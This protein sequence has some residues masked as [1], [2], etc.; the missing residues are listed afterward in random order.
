[1]LSRTQIVFLSALAVVASST[2]ASGESAPCLP[3]EN[4][5]FIF[6]VNFDEAPGITG[7]FQVEGCEGTSPVLQI[8]R[9]VEYE[10]VQNAMTNWNHPI[11]LAYYPD[12]ALGFGNFS[13]VPELENPTPEDCESEDFQCN[14]GAD[15]EQAPLYCSNG[16]CETL[17]DWN[18]GETGLDFY[19]PYFQRPID[20]WIENTWSVRITIPLSSL[21]SQFFYF[22]HIHS[23]MSGLINVTDPAPDANVLI[24]PWDPSAYYTARDS[25]D[26]ACGTSGLEQFGVDYDEF[27]PNM[28]FVCPG[29]LDTQYVSCL[30][31]VNCQMNFEMRVPVEVDPLLNFMHE[32]IPHHVN[33]VNMARFAMKFASTSPGYDD[34]DFAIPEMML[35]IINAQNM[36]IQNMEAF[37]ATYENG[38]VEG[39]VECPEAS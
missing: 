10:F 12:G 36:Q 5:Q 26:E 30:E 6:S 31:A 18:N 20:Q 19:E 2:L 14:P 17:D 32:M 9:G 33:A 28:E 37:L 7:A 3:N 15:V 38:P 11:G 29:N 8:V 1:M 22:C 25:F 35:A 4:N 27:C 13:E 16:V 24:Q 23:G 39:V 21:T 34:P